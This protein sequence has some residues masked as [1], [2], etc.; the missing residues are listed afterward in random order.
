MGQNCPFRVSA[1]FC[2]RWWMIPFSPASSQLL[3]C[4][5]ANWDASVGRLQRFERL[6]AGPWVELGPAVP[7]TLW[8]AGLAGGRGLHPSMPRRPQGRAAVRDTPEEWACSSVR[9]NTCVRTAFRRP[10]RGSSV[11]PHHG[12]TGPETHAP[13]EQN[14]RRMRLGA[15]GFLA[16]SFHE[17]LARHAG[18]AVQVRP[19]AQGATYEWSPPPGACYPSDLESI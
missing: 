7:V 14:M 18:A 5:A 2:H 6:S 17:A 15:P 19:W 16:W 12:G 11:V 10:V 4:L 9:R 3:L 13:L 8:R 1:V